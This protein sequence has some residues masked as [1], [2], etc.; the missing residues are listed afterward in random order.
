MN[1]A[2]FLCPNSTGHKNRH[3][4]PFDTT[5]AASVDRYA[6]KRILFIAM[7][8]VLMILGLAAGLYFGLWWAFIGGI[9]S[10]IQGIR[11]PELDAFA[12]AFGIT[13]VIFASFIGCMTFYVG[14]I[15][16][17]A[18]IQKGVDE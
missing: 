8:L 18:F 10:V 2:A 15:L 12:I 14:A 7:G 4:K 3:N 1:L 16:G 9:V 13:R 6:M 11:A 5:P 17:G